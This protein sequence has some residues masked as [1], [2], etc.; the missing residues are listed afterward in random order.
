MVLQ[1]ELDLITTTEAERLLLHSRSRYYEHGDSSG[2]LLA[3]QLRRQA[4]SRL[5]PCIKDGSGALQEDP[6][7]NNSVF[8]LFMNPC[9]GLNSHQIRL[10]CTGFLDEL[11]FPS[12]NPEMVGQLDSG[13][14]YSI[15]PLCLS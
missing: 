1:T 8:H 14:T 9:T 5:I 6:V 2:R 13:Q 3:H 12:I 11:Q 15:T 4:A 10:I 7:V